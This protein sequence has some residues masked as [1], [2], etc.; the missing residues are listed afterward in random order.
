MEWS[1]MVVGGG[2]RERTTTECYLL[3]EKVK[4]NE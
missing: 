3:C 1:G 4:P 2:T